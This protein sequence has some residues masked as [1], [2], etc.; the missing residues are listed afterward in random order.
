[1][2]AVIG[3]KHPK[4]DERPLLFIVRKPGQEVSKEEI[5]AF[6]GKHQQKILEEIEARTNR[7]SK[8]EA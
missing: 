7:N 4:W 5:L 3:V 6:H 8:K 2:A 1:M